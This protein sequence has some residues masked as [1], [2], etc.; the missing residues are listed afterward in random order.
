MIAALPSITDQV[1]AAAAC[2]MSA[3]SAQAHDV[4]TTARNAREVRCLQLRRALLDLLAPGTEIGIPALC[5]RLPAGLNNSRN[6]VC[7]QLS[8]L[9]E[10]GWVTSRCAPNRRGITVG[11]GRPRVWRITSAGRVAIVAAARNTE[12]TTS[13]HG[14]H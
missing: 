3:R 4:L 9:A 1:R 13:T 2:A 5:A 10:H 6:A 14:D 8:T 7:L 11:T 12:S